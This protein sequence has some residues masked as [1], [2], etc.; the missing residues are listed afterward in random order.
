MADD[1][2]AGLEEDAGTAGDSK[3]TLLN[4]SLFGDD[5]NPGDTI[6]LKV[7]KVY[8]DQVEAAVAEKEEDTETKEPTVDEEIDMMAQANEDDYGM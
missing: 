4:K 3:T 6:T 7:T 1:N 5:V 2:Y 8:K